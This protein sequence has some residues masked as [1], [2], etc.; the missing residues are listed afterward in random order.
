MDETLIKKLNAELPELPLRYNVSFREITTLGIGGKLPVVAEPED[1]IQLSGL[2]RFIDRH[3]LPFLVIGGGSNIAGM[4]QDFPGIAIRLARGKFAEISLGRT[5]HITAGAA[6]RM[7]IL[8]D[9]AAG[10]GMGGLAKLSGIP[11]S[12]GGALRMN[13]GARGVSIGDLAIQ[14]CGCRTDGTVW[15]AEASDIS[16]KYRTTSIPDDVIITSAILRLEPAEA[17][18]ERH[19]ISAEKNRRR[20]SEPQGRSAGCIFKNPGSGESAGLL[21]DRCGLKGMSFG[22]LKVSDTHANYII[23]TGN[24]TEAD[25]LELM[26]QIRR[27]VAEKTGF[28]LEPEVRFAN[29]GTLKKYYNA[30]PAPKVAVLMGGVSSE[31]DV[32]LRSG[33][34]VA[35]ALR[36]AGY[37]VSETDLQKCEITEEMRQADAVYSLLHGGFG[38]DGRLQKLMEAANIRFVGSGSQAC[39]LMMNKL[40]SKELLDAL[41]LPTAKWGTV[42]PENRKLPPGLELP[43][44]VKAPWEGSTVGIAIVKTMDE[45]DSVLDKIFEYDKTL[46]VEEFIAGTEITVPIVNGQVLPAIE[47]R[48]PRGFYDYDA[49]YV[50]KTGRTQYFC[51]AETVSEEA[52]K[53]AGEI[54]LRFYEAARCRDILRVDF[55]I[56]ADDTPLVLEGNSIP[57]C[58]ATSLV[59]K[60]AKVAG[61]SFERMTMQLTQAALQR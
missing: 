21:I 58:T 22:D 56:D 18:E 43:V 24:G 11:G 3:G 48:S 13:A 31:R 51:P 2:M 1:D 55:I 42:T 4:D 36:N 49:K 32:S 45:W 9:T 41:E 39:E 40:S 37:R 38:E 30:V 27:T 29:P 26:I 15:T 10:E 20:V 46:L 35:T 8:A 53:R 33:A 6:V 7:A 5:R 14:L 16:W 17:E 59:P 44:V 47:I 25:L 19:N 12:L 61:I 50:Y 57:G 54:A 23:N 28:Y 34:A 52:L 60:A